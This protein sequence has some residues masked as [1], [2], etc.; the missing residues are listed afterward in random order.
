MKNKITFFCILLVLILNVKM[1][2]QC[3]ENSTGPTAISTTEQGQSLTPSCTESLNSFTFECTLSCTGTPTIEVRD[4]AGCAGTLLTSQTFTL[5]VGDNTINFD[6]P[7]TVTNG[8]PFSVIIKSATSF[9]F[10]DNSGNPYSGGTMLNDPACDELAAW[11][12]EFSYTVGVLP[13][14]LT[15]FKGQATDGG[16]LL[17]WQTASETNNE[18]FEIQHSPDGNN[19]N[20]L[21]FVPG[22]GTTQTEQVYSFIDRRPLPGLNYYRLKQLDFDGAFEYSKVVSVVVHGKEA[23]LQVYPNPAT[24][25][26]NLVFQNSGKGEVL[27]TLND[28]MGRSI[29]EIPFVLEADR[30]TQSIEVSEI[31][32]GVYWIALTD[33]AQQWQEKLI[34]K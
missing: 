22:H 18:G 19:W 20:D 30:T 23:A 10:R 29:K 2:G 25:T 17:T 33:G 15:D 32:T 16:T 4:G 14:E 7:P 9:G 21:A 8:S 5:G 13:V 28:A 11:D 27:L 24:G 34:V 3:S 31:P 6:T 12:M 26:F 1:Y